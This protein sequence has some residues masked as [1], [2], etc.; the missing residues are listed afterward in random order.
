MSHIA[1][2][3]T[4]V[5]D[6]AAVRAACRRLGLPA[7]EQGTVKLFSGEATGLAVQLPDWTYPVVCDTASGQLR[8]DNFEGRWGDPK[9]LDGF[10]QAYAVAKA[11]IEAR[12]R[13]HSTTEQTL[14][15]GSIKL[16]I[17]VA[18]GVA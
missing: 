6:A 10:K 13:G 3:K 12:R 18:G 7:P 9:H 8:Y 11:K 17:Q 14:P 15:D 2:I 5:R 16:T 1:T 4:Q